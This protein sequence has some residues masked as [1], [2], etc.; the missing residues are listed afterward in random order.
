MT[1]I[2]QSNI[3]LKVSEK[4]IRT[5]IETIPDKIWLKNPQGQFLACNPRF[6]QFLNRKETDIPGKTDYDFVEKELAD[7]FALQD[8][9][10][11][12]AGKPTTSVK[13]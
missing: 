4:M 12:D 3:A 13:K 7:Y 10:A 9:L 2:H 8:K 11:M 5:I 1:S 6:E